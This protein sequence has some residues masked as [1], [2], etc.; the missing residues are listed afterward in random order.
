MS[1]QI[2]HIPV[3]IER[4]SLQENFAPAWNPSKRIFEG[5]V[6]ESEIVTPY[7]I[8]FNFY[9]I[10]SG[11]TYN[12]VVTVK[13]VINPF[14]P[15]YAHTDSPTVSDVVI[16]I[17]C[18]DESFGSITFISG[19][20]TGEVE[21]IKGIAFNEGD[22]ISLELPAQLSQ[23]SD[24][25]IALLGQVGLPIQGSFT[26]GDFIFNE[27][28]AA[29]GEPDDTFLAKLLQDELKR[30]GRLY[31]EFGPGGSFVISSEFLQWPINIFNDYINNG[32]YNFT[33]TQK[34]NFLLK[35][36]PFYEDTDGVKGY[37]FNTYSPYGT[38]T[39]AETTADFLYAI[40]Y[41]GGLGDIVIEKTGQ[42]CE[43][44]TDKI[45][46][47]NNSKTVSGEGTAIVIIDD[48]S[49]VTKLD[50]GQTDAGS[51]LPKLPF[52][53]LEIFNIENT[54]FEIASDFSF[55]S[56]NI[57]NINI[58]NLVAT[59]Q[60]HLDLVAALDNL[61][62][63][64]N[65]DVKAILIP[66]S[67][68]GLMTKWTNAG[69]NLTW[70]GADIIPGNI[71]NINFDILNDSVQV[72]FDEATEG[73]PPIEVV[74]RY[75]KSNETTWNQT[76][77]KANQSPQTFTIADLEYETEYNFE[78]GFS[79]NDETFQ[80]EY[81]DVFTII[82]PELIITPFIIRIDTTLSSDD[83]VR[84][85]VQEDGVEVDWGDGSAP[86]VTQDVDS[87][88]PSTFPDY[89]Y[90]NPGV[91]DIQIKGAT[92]LDFGLVDSGDHNDKFTG[93][94]FQWGN[95]PFT[96]LSFKNCINF[97][98]SNVSDNPFFGPDASISELFYGITNFNQ[99]IGSWDVSNV[100]N[101]SRTFQGATNFNQD[102]GSWDVSNVLIFRNTF[103]MATN[104][105]QDISSWDVSNATNM[106]DMFLGATN[107]NQDIGSWNVGNVTN[108]RG[109]FQGATN[110]NQD[111]GSWDV[112]NVLI[113]RN[114]FTMATNF[115]QD[116]SSWDVGNCEQMS[117]MFTA[118]ANFNQNLSPWNILNVQTDNASVPFSTS[119]GMDTEN[120]SKTL[121]GWVNRIDKY[122]NDGN[123]YNNEFVISS[124][125]YDLA[126]NTDYSSAPDIYNPDDL[127][128]F[129]STGQPMTGQNAVDILTNTYNWT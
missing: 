48:K 108:M 95:T 98:P 84:I 83:E 6:L 56:N 70:D 87:E 122:V 67:V 68:D 31:E 91:Y 128:V 17:K 44:H 47:Q 13:G 109:M 10:S 9:G 103:T 18:N 114:T 4:H 72:N 63:A 60:M 14:I 121:I 34:E 7:P 93:E 74:L 21:L 129:R 86:I 3:T 89:T 27:Y 110:F 45:L 115:N 23:L 24:F 1:S 106:S 30:G 46:N 54:K 105:N 71:N 41:K 42:T 38:G 65:L 88:L 104:F 76:S 52:T 78:L 29:T 66:D 25:S 28:I 92:K 123:T 118:A 102:I 19:Q 100:T 35:L 75:K 49:S 64:F 2:T 39:G 59:N 5:K 80:R 15:G 90:T 50:F 85:P 126:D 82:T 43:W 119:G 61:T 40:P 55:L 22:V 97:N 20:N 127:S 33:L 117:F 111:I 124:G 73:I 53:N 77:R 79:H 113:F 62:P 37:L 120:I 16:D 69:Y 81:S 107:F 101:M 99:D 11:K 58:D 112:S 36:M 51:L 32:S 96:R 8:L 94:I 26:W 116:I 57:Q 12:H 125:I